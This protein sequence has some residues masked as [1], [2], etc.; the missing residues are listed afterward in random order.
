VPG[1]VIYFNAVIHKKTSRFKRL[2]FLWTFAA[3]R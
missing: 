3:A 2:V 1:G